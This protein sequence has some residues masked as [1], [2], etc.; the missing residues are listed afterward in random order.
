MMTEVSVEL[1]GNPR[2][3]VGWRVE[4]AM[5]DAAAPPW[6]V[7]QVLTFVRSIAGA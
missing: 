5:L 6:T 4:R 7:E 2:I 1:I 3:A